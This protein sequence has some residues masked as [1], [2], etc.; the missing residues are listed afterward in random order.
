MVMEEIGGIE[1]M[2]AKQAAG[3]QRGKI[4]AEIELKNEKA[5]Q[6]YELQY[7]KEIFRKFDEVRTAKPAKWCSFCF[8]CAVGVVLRR[9]ALAL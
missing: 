1:G 8:L 2:T 3:G 4:L 5:R 9:A 7:V 6:A